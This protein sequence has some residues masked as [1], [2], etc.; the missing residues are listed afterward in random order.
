MDN[1]PT[2]AAA[3]WGAEIRRRREDLDLSRTELATRVGVSRTMV[4]LWETAKNAPSAEMQGRLV[5]VL[6]LDVAAIYA[7]MSGEVAS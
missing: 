1:D 3:A 2:P 4:G 5:T 6:G 7:A